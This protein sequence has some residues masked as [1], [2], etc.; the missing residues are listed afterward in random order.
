MK[1]RIA[2]FIALLFILGFL[3]VSILPQVLPP[4]VELPPQGE[5][6][7]WVNTFDME[8]NRLGTAVKGIENERTISFVKNRISL[9]ESAKQRIPEWHSKY[10]GEAMKFYRYVAGLVGSEVLRP[11]SGEFEGSVL[12][13]NLEI[14]RKSGV[15]LHPV[16]QPLGNEDIFKTATADKTSISEDKIYQVYKGNS[17]TMDDYFLRNGQVETGSNNIVTSVVFDYR[18]FDTLGEGTVLFIAVSS[19]SMLLFQILKRKKKGIVEKK[20]FSPDVSRII[21]YSALFLF[22]LIIVFGAYLVVHGHLTP[23]GGF[24][25]GAVMASGTALILVAALIARDSKMTRK[26]LSVFESLAL[27]IFICMGFAGMAT[28]FLY[29]FLATPNGAFNTVA[30]GSNAGDITSA[31][32][33]PILSLAVGIEVFCGISIILV[34][35]FH[36]SKPDKG[37][38]TDA[39]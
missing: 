15:K 34:S 19:I 7:E 36:A 18:A 2:S 6:D 22:P 4:S 31:G 13:R 1:I 11:L 20:A 35:L 9:L 39:S 12:V 27:T 32:I 37:E 23:G 17:Y 10:Q 25:G 14:Y 8:I 33:L 3:F 29:N 16:G 38:I 24:Q 26:I 28:A 5:I 30:L 21:A